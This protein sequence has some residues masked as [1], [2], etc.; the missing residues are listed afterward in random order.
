MNVN[1]RKCL[2]VL[3][4]QAIRLALED[5]VAAQNSELSNNQSHDLNR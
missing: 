2:Q 3:R 1:R 4:S 5:H